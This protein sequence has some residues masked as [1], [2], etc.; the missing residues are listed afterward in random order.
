MRVD[1]SVVVFTIDSGNV[2]ER[3]VLREREAKKSFVE[4]L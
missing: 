2:V 3:I 4:N 1:A